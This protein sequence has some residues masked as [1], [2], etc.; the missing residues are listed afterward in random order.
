[1]FQETSG[2]VKS[3]PSGQQQTRIAVTKLDGTLD[4]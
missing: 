1:M 2:R 4:M 3:F